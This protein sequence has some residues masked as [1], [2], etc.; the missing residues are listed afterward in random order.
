MITVFS[1]ADLAY[2]ADLA[3]L[4]DLEIQG[5]QIFKYHKR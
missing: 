5:G 4:A 1:V 3:D 2:L